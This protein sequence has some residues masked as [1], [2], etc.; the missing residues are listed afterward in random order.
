M[1]LALFQFIDDI[2]ALYRNNMALYMEVES[3]LNAVFRQLIINQDDTAVSLQ[4]RIKQ[5]ESLREKLIRKQFYLDYD[6]PEEALD[7]LHDLIGITVQCRFIRNEMN[8]YHS[9]LISR[10][11]L[12][13]FLY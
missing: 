9:L 7:N 12:L 1:E 2:V 6:N 5:E 3:I 11:S 13:H 8:I 10:C 4:T